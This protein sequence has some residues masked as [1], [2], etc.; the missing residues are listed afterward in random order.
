MSK[1]KYGYVVFLASKT[2]DLKK[3]PKYKL[4]IFSKTFGT[5][6]ITFQ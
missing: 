3:A 1:M 6:L 2:G 4:A 5:I